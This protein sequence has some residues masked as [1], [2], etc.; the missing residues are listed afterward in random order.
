MRRTW[1][2]RLYPRVWR[3]RY[4]AEVAAMLADEKPSLRLVVDLLA[5]AIDARLNPQSIAQG[6]SMSTPLFRC[7]PVAATRADMRKS[8]L[9]MLGGTL[10]FALLYIAARHQF[11]AAR[12]YL[13]TLAYASF[14]LPVVIG[15]YWTQ[16]K[17]YDPRVRVVLILA[18]CAVIVGILL[19]A[20]AIAVR[21]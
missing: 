18:M 10:A 17:P 16:L 7:A 4:G 3:E 8:N 19:A 6:A 11:P 9:T 21:L 1:L 5:G 13:D 20:T 2:L 12:P 15:S 14:S